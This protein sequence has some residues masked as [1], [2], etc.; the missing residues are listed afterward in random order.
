MVLDNQVLSAPQFQSVIAGD[1]QITGDFT[2]DDARLLATKLMHGALPLVLEI[3][4][5]E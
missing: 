5:V 1:A 2:A 3:E 4:P